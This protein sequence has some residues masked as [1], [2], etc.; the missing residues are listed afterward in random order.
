MTPKRRGGRWLYELV[1]DIITGMRKLSDPEAHRART[2]L[3]EGRFPED[4]HARC[5]WCRD[6][7]PAREGRFIEV[8]VPG[9]GQTSMFQCSDCDHERK[10]AA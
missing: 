8:N 3:V 1:F 6:V 10:G 5:A 2:A 9:T 4:M 7:H